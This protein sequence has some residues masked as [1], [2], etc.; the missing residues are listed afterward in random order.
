MY[1]RSR[2]L[3]A[4]AMAS[5]DRYSTG[6]LS[7]K[8]RRVP[9]FLAALVLAAGLIAHGVGG[10]DIFVKSAANAAGGMSMPSGMPMP[11][12][13]NGC[14]GSEKGVAPAVCAAFC[15]AV[16]ALPV[17]PVVLHAVP[18]ETPSPTREPGASGLADP[19]DPHPPRSSILS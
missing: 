7:D 5:A 10:P 14:A 15:S 8:I 6:M 1:G 18:A 13:C 11:G 2:R 16:I 4:L 17:V 12:K 19:P 9:A 3:T